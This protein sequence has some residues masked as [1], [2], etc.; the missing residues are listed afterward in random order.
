MGLIRRPRVSSIQPREDRATQSSSSCTQPAIRGVV[1]WRNPQAMVSRA[2]A[3]LLRL[4]N[5]REHRRRLGQ[6]DQD[7]VRRQPAAGVAPHRARV[8]VAGRQEHLRRP[9]VVAAAAVTERS[10]VRGPG[11]CAAPWAPPCSRFLSAP[12]ALAALALLVAPGASAG[13]RGRTGRRCIRPRRPGRPRSATAP[14][15]PPVDPSASTP[16]RR[17]RISRSTSSRS[18]CGARLTFATPRRDHATT[19]AGPTSRAQGEAGTTRVHRRQTRP[20][21]AALRAKPAVRCR[22][23]STPR[24]LDERLR[25]MVVSRRRAQAARHR[26]DC[27]RRPDFSN[28]IDTRGP[29]EFGTRSR[30]GRPGGRA[31]LHPRECRV[32]R[33]APRPP[34]SRCSPNPR[35]AADKA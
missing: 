3:A 4:R 21:S 20:R 7:A 35:S 22:N 5:K 33:Q 31:R 30:G 32:A 27:L 15:A 10:V 25:A 19:R 11:V 13:E 16:T 2:L 28:G 9:E 18:I 12:I 26:S 29:R 17:S 1:R 34:L 8:G 14:C 24:I 6:P 23:R